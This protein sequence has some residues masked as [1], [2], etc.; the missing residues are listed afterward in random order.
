[1][2]VKE[3]SQEER[4]IYTRHPQGVAERLC[5]ATVGIA[6]LGGLGSAVATA[7]AR[8]GVGRLILVDFD[9]VEA[10][11]LNR[12]HYFYD[13]IGRKK[14]QALT[15]NLRRINPFPDYRGIAERITPQNAAALFRGADVLV[16]ALDAAEEKAMLLNSCSQMT[17]V[18]ASG[19]GGL[20]PCAELRVRRMGKRL[21]VVGD[22]HSDM[23]E[24]TLAS[25]VGVV[26]H[27][28]AH[29]VIR[30]LTGAEK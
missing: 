25:R 9:R 26:A 18:A 11:N 8:S 16:E 5:E 23:S 2:A 27:M 19:L 10:S 3:I 28:Q 1:M 24:G 21:F 22:M 29:L 12:Q 7:L 13:Q 14:A 17:M 4:A 30:I 20:G 6:G 15:E